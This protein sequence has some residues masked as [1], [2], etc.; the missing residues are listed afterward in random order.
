MNLTLIFCKNNEYFRLGWVFKFCKYF[1][2]ITH[3]LGAGTK[4]LKKVIIIWMIRALVTFIL[5]PNL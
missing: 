2:S 3:K 5:T 1:P 4:K